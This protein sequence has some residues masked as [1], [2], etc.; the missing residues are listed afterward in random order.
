LFV[1]GILIAVLADDAGGIVGGLGA[2]LASIGIGWKG[3]GTSAGKT[4]AHL[5]TPI[6][7]ASLDTTIYE[8]ITPQSILDRVSDA[9]PGTD[10]PSLVAAMVARA[11]AP[12]T[13]SPP[14]PP[15]PGPPGA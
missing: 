14:T 3:L 6:W 9:A 12:P 7:E 1:I 5:E 10:E 2:I 13:P 4:F 8:R 11:A 15:T